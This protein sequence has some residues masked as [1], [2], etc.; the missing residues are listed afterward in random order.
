MHTQTGDLIV[1]VFHIC[2]RVHGGQKTALDSRDLWLQV[3]NHLTWALGT[4][5]RS[6]GREASTLHAS[7]ISPG[8]SNLI[9]GNLP[10]EFNP[11]ERAK[12]DHGQT[13]KFRCIIYVM[14]QIM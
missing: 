10:K 9:Y 7:V 3:V 5:T 6:T 12:E 14:Q 8:L 1:C 11:G 13:E 2:G 4:E